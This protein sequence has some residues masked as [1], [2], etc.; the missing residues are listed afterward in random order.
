MWTT[1]ITLESYKNTFK[2][3]TFISQIKDVT[4]KSDKLKEHY[5]NL[6]FKVHNKQYQLPKINYPIRK[7]LSTCVLRKTEYKIRQNAIQIYFMII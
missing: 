2:F 6:Y 3:V 1:L 4:N 5:L 7:N